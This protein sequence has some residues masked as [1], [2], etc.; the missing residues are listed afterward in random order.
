MTSIRVLHVIGGGEIGGAEEHLLTLMGLLDRE[1]FSP[2]LLCLCHGPFA[3]VARGR[4]IP[5]RE[6]PMRHKLDLA[7][8]GPIRQ[9]LR[10]QNIDVVHTH[11]VRANLVARLAAHR[12]ELPVVTTLHSVLRYDY[13]SRLEAWVARAITRLTNRYTDR[14]IA[15]SA[16]IREDALAMGIPAERVQVIYNGLDVS[17]FRP[18]RPPAE[19]RRELSLRE[20][21]PVVAV[22]GRLHPV[23]GQRYFLQAASRL[24]AV[25]PGLQFLLVGEGPARAELQEL[26][27][28]LGLGDSVTMP[29]YFPHVEELYPLID[30]LCVPS[31]MEGLGLVVLEAMHFGTPVVA[32][33]VGGIPELITD[34]REGLLVPPRDSEALA[35]AVARLLDDRDL[36]RRLAEA[37]RQRVR[38]FTVESMAR[39]VEALYR[40]L[41]RQQWREKRA[42]A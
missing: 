26:A 7:V 16:A 25:R 24:H 39:Q 40:Q 14:F 33:A 10:E 31:V 37:G 13:R 22:I 19:V 21:D 5:T 28:F 2:S 3:A 12:E 9:L 6:I 29:G 4:G 11:G 27:E 20:E 15:I 1:A 23:K 18:A 30:V 38:E 41:V 42:E 17:R 35:A 8:V 34:Q 32:T 36:A